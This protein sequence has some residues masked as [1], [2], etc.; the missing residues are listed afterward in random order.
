[1][2]LQFTKD[3]HP[4]LLHDYTVDRT[5]DGT[6]EIKSLTLREAKALDFGIKYGWVV[7][8]LSVHFSCNII[9]SLHY[10]VW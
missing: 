2:D 4:V 1:M 10:S 3:G 7:N 6:G 5:S 8:Y 9:F